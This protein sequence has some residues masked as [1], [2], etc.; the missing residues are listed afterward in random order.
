[1]NV[2]IAEKVEKLLKSNPHFNILGY[3]T[4]ISAL[5]ENSQNPSEFLHLVPQM[6]MVR[7]VND[8]VEIKL[9]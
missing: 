3:L 2:D 5:V 6:E 7:I 1:M 4:H 9:F 8:D